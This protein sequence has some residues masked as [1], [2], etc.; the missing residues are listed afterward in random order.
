MSVRMI[1][2]RGTTRIKDD[3]SESILSPCN[4]DV[5]LSWCCNEPKT[6]VRKLIISKTLKG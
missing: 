4:V 5:I 3:A 2:D 6:F 1:T